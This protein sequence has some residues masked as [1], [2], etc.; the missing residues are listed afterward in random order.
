[1]GTNRLDWNV[2]AASC[3]FGEQVVTLE[4]LSHLVES[5]ISV[6]EMDMQNRWDRWPVCDL[7]DAW[8]HVGNHAKGIGLVIWSLHIPYGTD[9]DLSSLQEHHR[10]AIVHRH[11][12][13]IA[14]AAETLGIRKAVVHPSF[15][16]VPE[17][18]REERIKR[19]RESLSYLCEQAAP[20]GVQVA[21]EDLPRTC[22][23]NTTAEMRRIVDGIDQ[24]GI[25]CDTNHLLMDKTEDFIRDLGHR[26]V[27]VHLSDYDF[28]N[29]RHWLP[30]K[31]LN[32]WRGILSA[33]EK[34]GYSGPAMFE[35]GPECCPAGPAGIRKC[36]DKLIQ[37]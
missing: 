8:K 9:N 17:N 2:G 34:A 37:R 13:L 36:W 33:L 14:A 29:E 4:D 18:E 12:A 24:L 28:V 11:A 20:Y 21:V 30:G 16:P 6:M 19:V 7:K 26:I 1:M 10:K 3:I 22:L 27:T 15:E 23:G 5:G 32:D 35:I 31:G 25:C